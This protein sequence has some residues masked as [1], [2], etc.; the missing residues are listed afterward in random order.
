MHDVYLGI[1][2]SA[3][4]SGLADL[5]EQ[6]L[7]CTRDGAAAKESRQQV[8][9]RLASVEHVVITGAFLLCFGFQCGGEGAER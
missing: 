3:I 4:A 2:K 8:A 5:L 1:A 6:G 9:V 7:L